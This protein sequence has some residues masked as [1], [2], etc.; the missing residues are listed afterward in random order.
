MTAPEAQDLGPNVLDRW[1]GV[2]HMVSMWSLRRA[3]GEAFR[4]RFRCGLEIKAPDLRASRIADT[5]R[6]ADCPAC[7]TQLKQGGEELPLPT[8]DYVDP[9][10]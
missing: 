5:N 8:V 1:T 9:P 3:T 6:E 2:T 7:W 10:P 4:V